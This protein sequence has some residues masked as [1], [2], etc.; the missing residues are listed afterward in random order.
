MTPISIQSETVIVCQK[1]G[2]QR[3]CPSTIGPD[4]WLKCRCGGTIFSL[5]MRTPMV[6]TEPHP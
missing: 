5:R 4:V 3:E 1:C 2:E 6:R